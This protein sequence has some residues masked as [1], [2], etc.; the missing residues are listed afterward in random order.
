MNAQKLSRRQALAEAGLLVG[1]AVMLKDTLL[2]AEPVRP[3]VQA[4]TSPVRYCLNTA[5][6]R[7]QKLG[8]LNEIGVAAQAGYDAIEPWMESINVYVNNGG[9]LPDLRNRIRD[10]GLTVEGVIGFA[11]WAV[12]DDTRRAK[13]LERARREMDLVAQIGGQ[14]MAAPP[15]GATRLPKLDLLRVAERYRALLEAGV[16]SGV[17]PVLELW[18]FS[19][20][21]GRLSECVAVAVETG[22]RNACVLADVFHLYKGGSDFHGIQLLGP[23]AIPVLHLN[24]YPSD[25]P[26]ETIDDSYRLYPGDGVAPLADLLRML[27]RTGGQKV[28]SLEIFNRRNWSE[29]ALEV[30]KTGLA[31]MKAVVASTPP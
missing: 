12:E 19:L 18:G 30:A 8:I 9:S 6:I 28:L 31:K 10:A 7:G 24:D 20:N 21:L 11:E 16:Q 4:P 23:E 2:K 1:A 22:H 3:P 13:G 29:G 26:R 17:V 27:R 15:A 5:T 25:P 14:R